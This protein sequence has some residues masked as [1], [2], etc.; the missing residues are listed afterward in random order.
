MS[1]DR[2]FLPFA[3]TIRIVSSLT[4]RLLKECFGEKQEITTYEWH[5]IFKEY[6]VY[7]TVYSQYLSGMLGLVSVRNHQV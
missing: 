4:N 7:E 1:V 3:K 2:S 5:F 6:A